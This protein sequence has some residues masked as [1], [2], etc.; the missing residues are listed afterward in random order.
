MTRICG[1]KYSLLGS[2][3]PV[4]LA[5]G[6]CRGTRPH[7]STYRAKRNVRNNGVMAPELSPAVSS[8]VYWETDMD[9]YSTSTDPDGI[10]SIKEYMVGSYVSQS[11]SSKCMPRTAGQSS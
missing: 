6:K 1:F 5:G 2:P 11:Q 7:R 8:S 3:D 4:R 10:D 9:K